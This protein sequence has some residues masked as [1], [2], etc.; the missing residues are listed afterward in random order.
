[1]YSKTDRISLLI[2]EWIEKKWEKKSG[3][4]GPLAKVSV[5]ESQ[6]VFAAGKTCQASRP[7]EMVPD[8]SWAMTQP[9]NP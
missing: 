8:R 3:P 4:Q 7:V 2:G 9:S 5:E 6:N 1:M